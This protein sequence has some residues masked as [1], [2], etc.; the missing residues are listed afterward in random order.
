MAT[1]DTDSLE[2]LFAIG[3]FAAAEYQM[4]VNQPIALHLAWAAG[5]WDGEGHVSARDNSSGGRQIKAVITQKDCRALDHFREIVGFGKIYPRRVDDGWQ[6]Q[7]A[8]V[9]Y[10]KRLASLLWP[11]LGEIKRDQFIHALGVYELLNT[12]GRRA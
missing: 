12:K 8:R 2:N 11:W 9:L 3:S 1:S 10:V 5:F 4:T 7:S 6:W